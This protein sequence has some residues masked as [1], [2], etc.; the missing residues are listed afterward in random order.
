MNYVF[1]ERAAIR[2]V[3]VAASMAEKITS[4]GGAEHMAGL[5]RSRNSIHVVCDIFVR[6]REKI[7][8]IKDKKHEWESEYS[9]RALK[10]LFR[11]LQ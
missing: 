10:Q 5:E 8:T 3:G 4:K 2:A 1:G 11:C 6:N 9:H 7:W